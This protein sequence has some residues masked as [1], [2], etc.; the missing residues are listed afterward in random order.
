MIQNYY[1]RQIDIYTGEEEKEIRNLFTFGYGGE[2]YSITQAILWLGNRLRNSQD[3]D[4]II[5]HTND[6]ESETIL[7][8]GK[9]LFYDFYLDLTPRDIKYFGYIFAYNESKNETY[10]VKGDGVQNVD[11]K[12]I[13]YTA[14]GKVTI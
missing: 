12:Y 5:Y 14:E 10:V 6:R 3:D 7:A 8:E 1:D 9:N 13:F 4:V 2:W 11:G